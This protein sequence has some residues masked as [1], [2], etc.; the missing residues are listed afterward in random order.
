MKRLEKWNSRNMILK[1]KKKKTKQ[2]KNKNKKVH[3]SGLLIS[4]KLPFDRKV[5]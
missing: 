4:T 3:M 5:K 1:P 2:N